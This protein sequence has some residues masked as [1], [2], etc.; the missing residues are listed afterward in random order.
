MATQILNNGATLKITISGVTKLLA[1][2]QIKEIT[3][4]KTNIVKI[5]I[6]AGIGNLF[7]T[8]ADVT[9]PAVAT[10][11]DLVAEINTMLAAAAVA[12]GAT[13]LKQDTTITQLNAIKTDIASMKTKLDNLDNKLFFDALLIDESALNAIYRGFA[14]PGASTSTAVWAI[15]R[16]TQVGEVTIKKWAGG[17]RNFAFIWDNREALTYS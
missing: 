5:D 14:L 9:V 15:E 13:E 11:D 16:T 8:Y 3:L 4:V 2:N 7:I 17:S 6:G 1:K 12:G 10:P